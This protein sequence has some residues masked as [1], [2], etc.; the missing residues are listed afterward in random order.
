MTTG[1]HSQ[2]AIPVGTK[3][4][5][6]KYTKEKFILNTKIYLL[7]ILFISALLLTSCNSFP[8]VGELQTES[9]SVDLGDAKSVSVDINFGTGNLNITGGAE[10]LMEADFKYNVAKFKP[11]VEYTD[12]T[13]VVEQPIGISLPFLQK[14]ADIRN[15]WNLHLSDEVPMDMS[16]NF[17]HGTSDLELSGLSLNHLEISQGTGVSVI[18]LNDQWKHDLDVSIDSGATDITVRLPSAIGVRVEIDSGRTTVAASGLTQEGNVYTNAAYGVSDVTLHVIMNPGTGR[19]GLEV[20]S[21]AAAAH[22]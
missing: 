11:Q 21:D 10:K 6:T 16:V 7:N 14:A 20:A 22:K 18:N 2:P 17:G 1:A 8:R 15:D 5:Q 3:S 9:R 12:S 13:L 4:T 19:I